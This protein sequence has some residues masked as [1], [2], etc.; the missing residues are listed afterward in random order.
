MGYH[1][2]EGL[3]SELFRAQRGKPVDPQ[4]VAQRVAR[5]LPTELP[6]SHQHALE[7][8]SQ[9]RPLEWQELDKLGTQIEIEAGDDSNRDL[10][11]LIDALLWGW[12]RQVSLSVR[13]LCAYCHRPATGIVRNRPV[14]PEHVPGT[15][16]AKRAANISRWAGDWI[17][18]RERV[19]AAARAV[20]HTATDS[21]LE[22]ILAT[23]SI[24]AMTRIWWER[25]PELELAIR[26]KA[27][28]MVEAEYRACVREQRANGGRRSGALGG[29]P[30]TVSRDALDRAAAD[31]RRGMS[32]R[33]AA[34]KN[35]VN[36][37]TLRKHIRD[38]EKS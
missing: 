3:I 22:D 34:D 17:V 1:A 2:V 32:K 26:I 4:A 25:Q 19:Y 30:Q 15:A 21:E 36:E 16:A 24:E 7:L 9:R 20:R 31:V 23:T 33:A 29:A 28:Q 13:G 27:H 38:R 14:C 11:I 8:A 10:N 12:Q 18:L 6:I 5:H 37:S 35:G